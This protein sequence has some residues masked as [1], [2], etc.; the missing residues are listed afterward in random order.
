MVR[1]TPLHTYGYNVFDFIYEQGEEEVG[2]KDV[3]NT[4]NVCFD[5]QSGRFAGSR[6]MRMTG[7]SDM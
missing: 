2:L 5:R 6:M 7:N 3:Q 1:I 4:N